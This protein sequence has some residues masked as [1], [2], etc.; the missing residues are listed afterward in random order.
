MIY[1]YHDHKDEAA[2]FGLEVY[3]RDEGVSKSRMKF[4]KLI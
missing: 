1:S 4:S 3:M 2:N